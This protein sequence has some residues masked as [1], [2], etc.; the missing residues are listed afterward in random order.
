M[1][2]NN[3]LSVK[4][5]SRDQLLM[6]L[7][8]A[9]EI[10]QQPDHYAEKAKGKILGL[11][12]FEPSTRTYFSFAS[13]IQRLGGNFLGFSDVNT[14][15]I[16]KGETL[17]D[18][19]KIMSG[20]ADILAVR[21]AELGSLKRVATAV[22]VPVI[23]AGEG[24]GEHPTQTLTDLFTIYKKL[25][26]L[27]ITIAFYNDLKYGR[28]A[29]SL[30]L[31]AAAMGA[32]LICIAPEELQ[33]PE[34]YIKEAKLLGAKIVLAK[35]LA[36]YYQQIDVLYVTRLQSERLPAELNAAE[37]KKKFLVNKETLSHL[38]SDTLIL[39][40][41][42]RI[43][44]IDPEIDSDPRALYFEQAKNGVAMRMA[45]LLHCLQI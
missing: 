23:N 22:N 6:L 16:T 11:L 32:N 36:P 8:K 28:T 15:S 34:E 10:E 12:F 5:L 38:R 26:R 13:A 44:E 40:P 31:A 21:H 17:E 29:H 4:S 33:M 3:L 19:A 30:L 2:K 43:G 35:E 41:L 14:I 20:Y 27:N 25:G 9:Q 7:K 45:I 24:I 18:T 37:L 1:K 42:P 39:H